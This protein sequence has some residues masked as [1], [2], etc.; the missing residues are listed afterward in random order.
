MMDTSGM[1]LRGVKVVEL[2]GLAPA[3]FCGLILSDFGAKVTRVD[4][5]RTAMSMDM[6]GRGKRSVAL[7][8]KQQEGVG[9]LRRMCQNSDVLIE[10]FRAGVMERLGLGPDI[11]MKDNPGL[12]YARMTGFGQSGPFSQMAGHDINYISLSGMLSRLGRKHENPMPPSNLLGDFAG[13]GLTCALGIV[14]AL[15]ERTMSG[16]G[17]VIDANMVEGASYVGSFIWHS[18]FLY[19]HGRGENLLDTGAHFYETYKTKDG[20]YMAVGALEPQFYAK[21]LE[22]LGLTIEDLPPQM[23]RESWPSMK[24]K[25]ATIF[26]SKTRAEWCELFDGTDACV[27]PILSMQEAPNHPHNK[28]R[29]SYLTNE[30]GGVQPRPAPLLSRTPGVG[31]VGPQPKIGQ[32]TKEVMV[33]TG[34][35]EEEIQKLAESGAVDL[36]GIKSA[37]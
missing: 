5:A 18:R 2:A 25:F 8:L 13:G 9:V 7:N 35:S 16:K 32:H 34:F 33:E 24:E 12:I 3:P 4:K 37:L 15:F 19:N 29:D 10:P 23:D 1:A 11:L 30:D 36:G 26:S 17:Q 21:L 31:G 28:S 22:G 20:E 6:M 27:T 14:M